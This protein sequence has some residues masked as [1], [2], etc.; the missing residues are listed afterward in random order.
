MEFKEPQKQ[1]RN[2]ENEETG[3]W[4]VLGDVM[5]DV[6]NAMS[7]GSI[8][9]LFY[10]TTYFGTF[11]ETKIYETNIDT[12]VGLMEDVKHADNEMVK[13]SIYIKIGE[14]IHELPNKTELQKMTVTKI[15]ELILVEMFKKSE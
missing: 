1:T 2:E 4:F 7:V 6:N 8:R 13:A 10:H 11:D 12:I 3:E 14:K 15:R 9:D 5:L